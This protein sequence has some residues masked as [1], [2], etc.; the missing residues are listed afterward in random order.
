MKNALFLLTA[1]LFLLLAACSQ[2]APAETPAPTET[3]MP[4]ATPLPPETEELSLTVTQADAYGCVFTLENRYTEENRGFDYVT[5]EQYALQ[6]RNPAGEWEWVQ[7]I[8][9]NLEPCSATLKQG[10]SCTDAWDWSYACGPLP[11]GEYSL[12]IWGNLG[13][14][15]AGADSVSVRGS[16]TLEASAPEGPGPLFFRNSPVWLNGSLYGRDLKSSGHRWTQTF[17]PEREGWA[18]ET[19]FF[20]YRKTKEGE[21]EFIPPEYNLPAYLNRTVI[22]HAGETVSFAVELAARYGELE[23]GTYVLR[24]RLICLTE[25]EREAGGLPDGS[26][27]L[28]PEER[29]VYADAEF[30]LYNLRDVPQGVDP[31]DELR[32]YDS[33]STTVLVSA[34]GSEFSSAGCTLRLKNVDANQW[35]DVSY[36]S[37]YY[38]LYFN[39]KLEWYP[40][41]HVRYGAHGLIWKTLAPGETQELNISF[42]HYFG[43]LPP[44][45]YRLVIACRALPYDK[46]LEQPEGFI[47]VNFRILEDGSGVLEEAEEAQ[48][49]VYLYINGGLRDREGRLVRVRIMDLYTRRWNVETEEDRLRLTVWQDRNLEQARALLGDYGC[50][51]IRRGE[52]P[53]LKPSPVTEENLGSRGT[54]SVAPIPISYP[55]AVQEPDQPPVAWAYSFTFAHEGTGAQTLNVDSHFH[56]EVLERGRWLTMTTTMDQATIELSAR[57]YQVQGQ[58]GETV[59]FG[60]NYGRL[61]DL[62]YVYGEFDPAKQYRVVL[63]MW[64]D[65]HNKEYYT[66]PLPLWD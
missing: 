26:F 12:V 23:R 38:C 45:S 62:S 16:F 43:E 18:T 9:R 34:V 13:A 56:I 51:D 63:Q 36:E 24:R 20:L 37:D 64:E 66:C 65:P 42:S 47:T 44:G 4:T 8:R 28:L 59:S 31:M 30:T 53:E 49:L 11:A 41:A 50:V 5:E 17:T 33:I 22:L 32:D 55:L 54:L 6:R 3:P 21:L 39:H 52:D 15:P 29:F 10:L 25:E 14:G 60:T 40:A 58:P 57:V 61:M 1:V 27:R 48:Q 7:P 19:E 2:A 46:E 35:Y